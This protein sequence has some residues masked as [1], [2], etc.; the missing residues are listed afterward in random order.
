MILTIIVIHFTQQSQFDTMSNCNFPSMSGNLLMHR[1][2]IAPQI[3]GIPKSFPINI[4]I[5]ICLGNYI[6][7][8]PG[9]QKIVAIAM[10]I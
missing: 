3:A 6:G 5:N 7:T 4:K 2:F 8:L 1:R 9:C 10:E